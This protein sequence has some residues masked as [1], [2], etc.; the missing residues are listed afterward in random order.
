[1]YAIRGAIL[2]VLADDT[3]NSGAFLLR[4][5]LRPLSFHP[6][7]QAGV[8]IQHEHS[9]RRSFLSLALGKDVGLYPEISQPI[10]PRR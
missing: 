9:R 10:T 3:I 1:M 4:Y 7:K 8:W 6:R 5:Q 2:V